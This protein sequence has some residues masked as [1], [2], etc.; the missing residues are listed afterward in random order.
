MIPFILKSRECKLI[1]NS[2]K[3]INGCLGRALVS[4]QDG[5]MTKCKRKLLGMMDTFIILI[6]VMISQVYTYVKSH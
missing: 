1:S 3:Q 5:E 4:L 6:L 2:R